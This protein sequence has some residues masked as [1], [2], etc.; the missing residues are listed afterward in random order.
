MTRRDTACGGAYPE[1]NLLFNGGLESEPTGGA[2]DWRIS[3]LE[4]VCAWNRCGR[5]SR[6]FATRLP[7]VLLNLR[8]FARREDSCL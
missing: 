2:F 6:R 8:F 4:G 5:S 7:A 1:P 3:R